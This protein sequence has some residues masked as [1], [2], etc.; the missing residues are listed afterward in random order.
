MKPLT[1]IAVCVSL[2]VIAVCFCSIFRDSAEP[3]PVPEPFDSAT[4]DSLGYKPVQFVK[5]GQIQPVKPVQGGNPIVAGSG[6][7]VR[8]D[9]LEVWPD[10]LPVEV[11]VIDDGNGNWWAGVWVAGQPVHWERLEAIKPDADEPSDW[12]AILECAWVRE[13]PDI[14][15]GLAWTPIAFAGAETGLAA[16]VDLNR[17]IDTAPDWAALCGHA[18][19]A[20]GPVRIGAQVGYRFGEDAGLHL[21]VS[22]GIGLDL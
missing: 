2:A 7:V 6:Y 16:T 11:S 1:I 14:G 20:Y 5:P 19:K 22:V 9:S 4:A 3:D 10:T 15:I 12:S 21:G 17:V 8:P 13:R 18:S